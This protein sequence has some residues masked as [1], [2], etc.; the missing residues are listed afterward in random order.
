MGSSSNQSP[1]ESNNK[2]RRVI[3]RHAKIDGRGCRIRIP[4][5]CAPGIF[6]LTHELGLRSDGE[7]VHWL[8]EQ[9]RPELVSQHKTH[10]KTVPRLT[11]VTDSSSCPNPVAFAYP[12]DSE[13]GKIMALV[14]V[15]SGSGP[16]VTADEVSMASDTDVRP[17]I[18]ATVVQASTVFYD[19]PATL[20]TILY[21]LF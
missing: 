7:T 6:Q 13:N 9:S 17:T 15:A 12:N 20:G 3:D 1:E 21:N 8:L 4:A 14:P 18:R 2:R 5:S 19:T 16:E 10:S 11:P